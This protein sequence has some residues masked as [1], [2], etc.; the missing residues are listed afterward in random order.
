MEDNL[1]TW[2]GNRSDAI[3]MAWAGGASLVA[4]L[5]YCG[6]AYSM[7]VPP[8]V[9]EFLGVVTNL[10]CV[11]LTTTQN[12]WNWPYGIIAVVFLGILFYQMQ[13]YSSM[14]LSLAYYLPI[15]FWGWYKWLYGGQHKTELPVTWCS[16]RNRALIVICAL[17][18]IWAWGTFLTTYTG[19]VYIFWDASIL[20]LSVVAQYL[21]TFKKVEAW[22]LWIC[23]NILSV[24]IYY[25]T[26]LYMLSIQYG[27]FLV[28][29]SLGRYRWLKDYYTWSI[30]DICGRLKSY[31]TL[32]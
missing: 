28:L 30:Y 20:G 27:L 16:W 18:I 10:I 22:F 23:V 13:L 4:T 17:P 21:L 7:G 1:T 15:Q 12:I 31:F 9:V 24:V 32:S 2:F 25:D 3:Q 19:A 11:Y 6:I 14:V 29:A 26:G 8:G 5:A